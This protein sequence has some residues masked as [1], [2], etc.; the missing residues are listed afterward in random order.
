[1]NMGSFEFDRTFDAVLCLFGG[2]GYLLKT[3]DVLECLRC[4]GGHLA[5]DGVF[6]LEFWQS[7]GVRPP[8]DRSWLHRTGKSIELFRLAESRY[9]GGP[10]RLPI[11]FRFFVF[12]GRKLIDRFHEIHTVRTYTN[13]GDAAFVAPRR[14]HD[15][16]G[17]RGC[18]GPGA[19][20]PA[21]PRGD[22]RGVCGLPTRDELTGREA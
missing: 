3:R 5:P 10:R 2:F 9:D 22:V 16:G 21:N 7:S 8:P 4:V 15:L 18:P 6:A 19:Q 20:V 1:G 17:L 12:K 13:G 14:A 11:D